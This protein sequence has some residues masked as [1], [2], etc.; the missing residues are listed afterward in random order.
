[1]QH[2]AIAVNNN[3]G[4]NQGLLLCE[5]TEKNATTATALQRTS[6]SGR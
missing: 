5:N 6:M 2:D 1:M 3:T 4:G